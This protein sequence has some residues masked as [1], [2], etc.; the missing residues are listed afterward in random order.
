M[1]PGWP[2]T[3]DHGVCVGPRDEPHTEPDLWVL[4]V[5]TGAGGDGGVGVG[6]GMG[7]GAAT[8]TSMK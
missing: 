4:G 7:G 2:D 3:A 8:I 5:W 1:T 6:V